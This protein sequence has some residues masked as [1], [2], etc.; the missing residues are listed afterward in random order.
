MTYQKLLLLILDGLGLNPQQYGNAVTPQSM[1]VFF[2]MMQQQS[3]AI[4]AASGE[5]VGL[6]ADQA[7]NSEIG[8]ATIG[9]G[10]TLLSKLAEIEHA[11]QN[12]CWADHAFWRQLRQE[13]RVH[14]VGTLSDAGVHAHLQ[15]MLQTIELAVAHQIKTIS[16]HLILDGVDAAVNSAPR[17]LTTLQQSISAYP[18]VEIGIIMG[19][20]WAMDRSGD[21]TVT[22]HCT[23]ALMGEVPLAPFHPQALAAH[24]RLQGSERNFP[25]HL[26]SQNALLKP[27]DSVILTNHR[28]DRVKQLAEVL[29][30]TQPVCSLADLSEL[31]GVQVFFPQAQVDGGMIAQVLASGLSVEVVAEA[32]KFSH[33]TYFLNGF[34]PQAAVRASKV[35]TIDDQ[36]IKQNPAMSI[37]VLEHAI[38]DALQRQPALLCV[39]IPNLDQVGHTG[40]L[41]LT[42]QAA[43][44]VDAC[45][46]RIVASASAQGYAIA[47]TADHGNADVMLNEQGVVQVSHSLNPVPFFIIPAAGST[48]IPLK[49]QGTLAN[50]APTLL[51]LMQLPVPTKMAPALFD[52]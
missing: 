12:G 22:Q 51:T 10:R 42:E 5:A 8:H 30:Q 9:A 26:V 25:A 33:V 36:A 13:P 16:V 45:F 32:C 44:Y 48:P 47:V 17:L 6:A 19:R 24:I 1:P 35:P 3:L 52:L 18:Q 50:I 46:E 38:E 43:A 39:N 49:P 21:F 15:A 14:I 41:V 29:L 28:A 34:Q 4:L 11:Y 40:D 23:S 20:Q 27:G 2:N 37:D 7:G 31:S